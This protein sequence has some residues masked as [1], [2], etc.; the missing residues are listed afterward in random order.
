MIMRTILSL[1]LLTLSLA[2]SRVNFSEARMLVARYNQVVS[3]AYR[4]GDI[5]LIDEVVGL[6]AP[7]GKRLT[8]LIGVRK[9]MGIALDAH[10]DNLEVVGV[11]QLKEDLRVRTKEQWRYRDVEVAT[12]RQVG[13]ASVD[14][15]EMIYH[16]K[17]T[18]GTWLVESTKFAAEPQVGRRE[19]PWSMSVRDAHGLVTSPT[20]GAKP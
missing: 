6:N 10:L 4:K 2:C 5:L 11:E 17:Y 12:G 3:E 14:R 15:Y 9:D 18:K 7:D 16:F 19:V 8:G 13:D 20:P 1:F